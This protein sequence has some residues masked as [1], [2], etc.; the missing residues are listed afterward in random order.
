MKVLGLIVEYNPFHNGH[1]YHIQK[2]KELV[3]PDVTIIVMSGNFVQRGE[4]AIVDKWTRTSVALEHGIDL[5]VELPFVYAVQS[6][7][8]FAKGALKILNDIGV[9][10]LVFGSENGNIEL[11]KDIAYAIKNDKERYNQ[12]IQ[13]FMKKG[14]RYP[15]ACNQALSTLLHKTI[16]TPND[17]L[18]LS[19]VKEVIYNNYPIT[20]HCITRT[21][22]FHSTSLEEISSAT[23]IRN[24]IKDKQDISKQLPN[25]DCYQNPVFF[26]D[27]YPY[28]KYKLLTTSAKELQTMHLVEEGLENLLLKWIPKVDTMSA[29][30]NSLTSKRYTRSRIQRMI[31]HIL[32]NNRKTEI[33]EAMQLDY[34]R[35]LGMNNTGKQYLNSI[36]KT[37]NTT[38][39]STFKSHQHPALSLEFKAT[40]LYSCLCDNANEMI[41]QEYSQIPIIK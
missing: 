1:I 34:V 15:D 24:A 25:I 39:I 6:A 9:T 4:P 23:A 16:T 12:L 40:K 14:Y 10:D 17:L 7:D 18:G 20:M 35:I 8:Y 21:N 13:S 22:D 38:L 32:M 36:K 28:L 3:Q 5:V 26:E 29:L 41:K 37:V 30:I 11:F 27:L 31:I 33:Q 2:A 19:Y